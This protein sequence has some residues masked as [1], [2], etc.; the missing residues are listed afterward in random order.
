[1]RWIRKAAVVGVAIVVGLG[2][3]AAPAQ[4]SSNVG[5]LYSVNNGGAVFF[6]ADLNDDSRIEKITVCDNKSDGRGVEAKVYGIT[7]NMAWQVADPSHDG[8]CVSYQGDLFVE[9]TR[10]QVAVWE[11]AGT[12]R[13]TVEYAI[14]VA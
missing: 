3:A 2:V 5:W 10:V 14:G 1:M 12:W 11:Y 13:S 8:K 7:V 4:A 6:D 9:E